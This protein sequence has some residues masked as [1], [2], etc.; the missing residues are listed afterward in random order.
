MFLTSDSPVRTK[1]SGRTEAETPRC[2]SSSGT[3]AEPSDRW[4]PAPGTDAP[5]PGCSDRGNPSN[6]WDRGKQAVRRI[7]MCRGCCLAVNLLPG[8]GAS[9]RVGVV[10]PFLDG[11]GE[12]RHVSGSMWEHG[13]ESR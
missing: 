11:L 10:D 1:T 9:L 12:N 3:T 13:K 7:Q 4:T 8:D 2:P 5:P 6:T